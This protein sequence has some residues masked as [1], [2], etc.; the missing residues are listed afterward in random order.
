MPADRTPAGTVR[1]VLVDRPYVSAHLRELVV[2]H[3]LPV[4]RTATAVE[5]GLGDVPGA[6]DEDEAVARARDADRVLVHTSSENALA[7]VARHLDFTGIPDLATAFK[8]KVR[9]RTALRS[10]YPDFY[11]RELGPD[12]LDTPIDDLPVPFVIKP[13]VGFFSLGVHKVSDPAEWAPARAAL[14]A[15]LDAARAQYP[16]EVLDTTRFIVEEC[17][18]GEEYAVDAYY[19]A[20]GRPV[21]LGIWHHD[22]ASDADTSDRVYTTSRAVVDDT[23]SD[24]T[25]CLAEMGRVTGARDMAV[26]VELRRD[27]A[28]AIRPIEVNPLR[29][30]GWCTTG[31]LAAHAYGFSPYLH[32]LEQ[33]E[34]DW[35]RVLDGMGEA[36]YSIIVLENS[37]G[38]DG[39]EIRDFD[40]DAVLAGFSRPLELRRVDYGRYSVFGV[41]FVETRADEQGE[42]D[43]ILHADLAR[44][45]HRR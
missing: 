36:R 39:R 31:D 7:W 38:I 5:L 11:F 12:E 45:I 41:L 16:A 44:F 15:G 37:T 4:V 6:L 1:L 22:F 27:A 19:D 17:I 32:F 9:F 29:F 3:R 21:V 43:A 14:R 34:P 13:S 33:R 8:D 30:G 2:A 40:Y 10:R 26:H 28:G 24:F 20:G 25:A 35:S 42:L 23:L 18:E